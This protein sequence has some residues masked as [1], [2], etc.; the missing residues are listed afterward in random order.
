MGIRRTGI[1]EEG[2]VRLAADWLEGTTEKN[3]D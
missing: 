1:V 2:P 3:G